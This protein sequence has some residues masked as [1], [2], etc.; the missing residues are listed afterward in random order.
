MP[1]P[2][3]LFASDDGAL[4]DTRLSGWSGRPPLR[5]AWSGHARDI[6]TTARV[7]AALRAGEYTEWGGYPLYFIASDGCALSFDAVCDNLASVL[8]SVRTGSSDGWRVVGV[9]INYEDGGLR[10]CHTGE[11]IPSAYAD[12]EESAA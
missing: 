11:R 7:K 12:E 10:C 8:D 9:A 6:K 3:H 4:Y 1:I 5:R 2:P